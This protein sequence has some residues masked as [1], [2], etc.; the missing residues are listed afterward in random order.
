[1]KEGEIE[2]MQNEPTVDAVD[3]KTLPP[4]GQCESEEAIRWSDSSREWRGNDP[5][6]LS[7]K[8]QRA[9]ED[10]EYPVL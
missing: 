5:V 6:R 9:P 7:G 1:M 8:G 2:N 3:G 4:K 10:V